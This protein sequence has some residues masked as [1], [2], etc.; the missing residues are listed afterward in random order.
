MIPTVELNTIYR[1]AKESGIIQ[2]AHHIRNDEYQED[3]FKNYKDINFMSC[4]SIDVVKNVQILVSKA[5]NEG[6][7]FNDIQV[8]APM[9]NG[10]AGIDALNEALQDLL[11]PADRFK[12]EIKVGK[13]IFRE[14]DKILQL[15][16]RVEDNVFNGDIGTLIE[17]NYKDN[18]EYMN[19]TIVVQ[20]DESIVEYT[21]TDFYTITHAYCM[22]I[23][24]SQGNE[25]KIVIMPILHDYYIMLK[26]NLIYTGL[27]RAKQSLFILGNY[28][29]FMHGINNLHDERRYT[30]L[31]EKLI[32][33]KTLSPYDFMD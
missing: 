28:K 33:N 27:T 20:Y 16:N 14:G 4:E 31:K 32:E 30:S 1:Q 25:F 26:K 15:K 8:L 9:Y 10:V 18:F 7:D 19:D 6:Y 11:N 3:D 13:R 24:K 21:S 22:S 23:H 29:A 12:N 17:I 2:L 5:M